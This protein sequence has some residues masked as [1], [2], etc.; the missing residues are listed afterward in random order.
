MKATKEEKQLIITEIAERLKDIIYATAT[1]QSTRML[2]RLGINELLNGD[3]CSEIK[4]TFQVGMYA[5]DIQQIVARH[6]RDNQE[7]DK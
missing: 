7:L 1:R 6:R 3:S 5:G 2:H 4:L